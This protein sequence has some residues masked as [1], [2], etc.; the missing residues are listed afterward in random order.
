IPRGGRPR[1]TESE[2]E[3]PANISGH[4]PMRR[5]LA[6]RHRGAAVRATYY[7]I[8][9]GNTPFPSSRDASAAD[10]TDA[11]GGAHNLGTAERG[12]PAGGACHR[13]PEPRPR[14]PTSLADEALHF[15]MVR[16]ACSR[17]SSILHDR[18]HAAR[19]VAPRVVVES[20]PRESSFC[21][22]WLSLPG[23]IGR[24][25]RSAR[26]RLFLRQEI[27]QEQAETEGR[28]ARTVVGVRRD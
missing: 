3:E 14:D 6:A 23:L 16:D 5:Q 9:L 27:V 15:A 8:T 12:A 18:E 7:R 2:P 11:C 20:C 17:R 25:P 24:E 1:A 28:P 13:I 22:P 4:D 21:D 10:G 26:Q 19:V